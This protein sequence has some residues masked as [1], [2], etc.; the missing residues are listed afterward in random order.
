MLD[1]ILLAFHLIC[2]IETPLSGGVQS[3]FDA[4]GSAVQMEQF[5]NNVRWEDIWPFD[6]PDLVP[7]SRP[8]ASHYVTPCEMELGS[9]GTGRYPNVISKQFLPGVI[10]ISG[11]EKNMNC[12]CISEHR[13]NCLITV[14]Y[15]SFE[16]DVVLRRIGSMFSC[17]SQEDLIPFFCTLEAIDFN[18]QIF[19]NNIFFKHTHC[20]PEVIAKIE[21]QD[22]S[23]KL[24]IK[25]S[26]S[27]PKRWRYPEYNLIPQSLCTDGGDNGVCPITQKEFEDTMLVYV[28]K[29]D[30]QKVLQRQPVVC[31]TAEGLRMLAS[32][33]DDGTFK[34][35]LNREGG[36]PLT[37]LKFYDPY[38]IFE[39]DPTKCDRTTQTDSFTPGKGKA[40]IP[41]RAIPSKS[42]SSWENSQG[43]ATFADLRVHDVVRRSKSSSSAASSSNAPS[44]TGIEKGSQ[45][46]EEKI[47]TSYFSSNVR[48]NVYI[49]LILFIV[50]TSYYHFNIIPFHFWKQPRHQHHYD[51]FL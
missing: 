23:K 19:A 43:L 16:H 20:S 15:G 1:V 24:G 12:E 49:L 37:I 17:P 31:I 39:D 36:Q 47:A 44:F 6:T 33:N 21:V 41:G 27:A 9:Q 25:R 45:T 38:V 50:L 40:R 2:A 42:L 32:Q 10:K 29:T 26:N 11:P 18:G 30:K 34:D 46:G 22:S 13:M 3:T 5:F 4:S 35:P 7:S 8:Q 28:M 51:A 48:L 14:R